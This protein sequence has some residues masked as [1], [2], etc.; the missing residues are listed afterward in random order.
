MIRVGDKIAASIADASDTDFY[1]IKTGSGPRDYYRASLENMGATLHPHLAW[2]DSNHHQLT[3]GYECYSQEALAEMDCSISAEPEATYYVEVSP[4]DGTSG[5][6]SL[7]VRPLKLYDKF[8]PNDDFPQAKSIPFGGDIEANIMDAHDADFYQLKPTTTGQATAILTNGG[9]K[10]HPHLT[11]YD[12]NHH[13]LTGGYE[14]YSQEA[15]A[16]LDCSISAQAGSTY[17]VEV[18]PADGT[19]GPYNLAVK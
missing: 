15:L 10:L 19:S 13:Q 11:W 17:Y 18:S 5:S 14:C 1:Q 8:E 12:A 2:F 16:E 3:G 9:T 4:V 7:Q 6:Y